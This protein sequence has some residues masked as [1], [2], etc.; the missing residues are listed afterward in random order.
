MKISELNELTSADDDDILPIVDTSANE[1]KRITKQNLV[2]GFPVGSILMFGGSSAPD[3]WLLC[4]GSEISRSTY[5][6]LFTAIGETF[7][8]GDRGTVGEKNFEVYIIFFTQEPV[9]KTWFC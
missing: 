2:G 4:D 3:G 5:S 8:I 1:T 7:G 9:D 6:D